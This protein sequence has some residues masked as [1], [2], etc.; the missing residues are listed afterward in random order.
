MAALAAAA[1]RRARGE[2]GSRHKVPVLAG[3]IIFKGA[4]VGIDA[5]G[6]A[7]PA[8]AGA[9]IRVAG[10]AA[11]SVTGGASN[12]AVSVEVET[13]REYLFAASSITQVMLG[14]S[15]LVVDDNTVDE[16]SAGSASVGSMTEF[17]ST[18][19][20]WVFVPGLS[21]PQA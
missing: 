19:S 14:S 11:E 18:T 16:T 15:M 7:K 3:A 12:G 1:N 17:V 5:A 9:G 10:I 8:V 2:L 4:I 13:R 20:C 6:F 21:V